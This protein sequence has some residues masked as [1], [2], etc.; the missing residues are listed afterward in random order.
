MH[1]HIF[2]HMHI[3]MHM[4][5]YMNMQF[6]MHMHIFMRWCFSYKQVGFLLLFTHKQKGGCQ[7]KLCLDVRARDDY[8][9]LLGPRTISPLHYNHFFSIQI[10]Y[11]LPQCSV[12]LYFFARSSLENTLV[13]IEL[14]NLMCRLFC[15]FRYNSCF[16][17]R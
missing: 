3:V 13:T 17:V 11:L 6:F 15:H 16:S 1:L 8:C 9:V 5:I 4:H 10:M 2:M 14:R 12:M 7:L